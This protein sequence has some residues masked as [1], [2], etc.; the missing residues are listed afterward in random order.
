MIWA[1]TPN[2]ANSGSS[3]EAPPRRRPRPLNNTLNKISSL[4][5]IIWHLSARVVD[6]G[7][8]GCLPTSQDR[9]Q[10]RLGLP[11]RRAGPARTSH[12]F[13]NLERVAVRPGRGTEMQCRHLP[14]RSHRVRGRQVKK[15]RRTRLVLAVVVVDGGV[16]S[17]QRPARRPPLP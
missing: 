4:S 7:L 15:V 1:L 11:L 5:W 10:D 12:L 13:A 8:P 2:Q 3:P 6:R 9:R 17:L 16:V 14:R